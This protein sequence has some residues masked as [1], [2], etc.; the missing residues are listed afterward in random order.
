[1]IEI[2]VDKDGAICSANG[3][4]IEIL[5][6]CTMGVFKMCQMLKQIGGD[7]LIDVFT[8]ALNDLFRMGAHKLFANTC[9]GETECV[10]FNP[11]ELLRQ[12]REEGDNDAK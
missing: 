12:M 1:M 2:K 8:K 9:E 3:K 6:D 4:A 11:A 5:T 10:Q 7:E